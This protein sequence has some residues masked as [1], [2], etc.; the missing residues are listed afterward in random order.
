MEPPRL[1]HGANSIFSKDVVN[2]L[3]LSGRADLHERNKPR[4]A[5]VAPGGLRRQ[6]IDEVGVV[7]GT[8]RDARF[9]FSF[10][11]GTKHPSGSSQLSFHRQRDV[12]KMCYWFEGVKTIVDLRVRETTDALRTELFHVERRHHG[13]KDHR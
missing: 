10:T 7:V 5:V 6:T 9:V 12:I 3:G 1:D 4:A 13:T 8:A 11:G 2:H